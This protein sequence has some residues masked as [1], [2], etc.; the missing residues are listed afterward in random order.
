MAKM[1]ILFTADHK[2]IISWSYDVSDSKK[3]L[4]T[5]LDL[6]CE[7]YN[8]KIKEIVVLKSRLTTEDSNEV[9]VL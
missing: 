7:M 1:V 4:R 3:T 2:G 9:R 5:R 6:L 8:E